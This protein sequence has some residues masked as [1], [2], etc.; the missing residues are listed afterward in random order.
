M[1]NVTISM[2]EELLRRIRIEAAKAETSVSKFIADT[3]GASLGKSMAAT[4]TT[5][6]A[7]IDALERLLSG[8]KWRLMREGRLPTAD[9]RN[10]R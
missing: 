3:L 10:E 5:R 4:P 7:Q 2:D 6:E 8:P 9:E 1:R